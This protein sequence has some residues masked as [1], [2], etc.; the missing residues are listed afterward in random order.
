L[1]EQLEAAYAEREEAMGAETMRF[2]E[3]RM[4]LGTIDRQWIDY[5]TAMDELRQ[6]IMLQAF[7]QR[8]PLIEFRKQSF[9]MFDQLKENITRDIVYQI[10]AQSFAYERYLRQ[11]ELE[12]KNR[13][14]TARAAG[15]SSEMQNLAAKPQRKLTNIGRNERC[16]CGS[17]KKFKHCHEGREEELVHLLAA[18]GQG[19]QPVHAAVAQASQPQ[20]VP[21][22]TQAEARR[23]R[24]VPSS[25]PRGKKR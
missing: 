16:P 13:L 1:V 25:V 5:L 17:G 7:A 20:A 8:D 3:R 9:A 21:A 19:A 12:Q 4:M 23:G 10:I 22:G 24:Q 18:Q 14:A 15:G 11:L 2:V 6:N